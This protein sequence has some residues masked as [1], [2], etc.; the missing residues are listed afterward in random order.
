MKNIHLVLP[1]LLLCFIFTACDKKGEFSSGPRAGNY[2]LAPDFVAN[3]LIMYTSTDKNTNQQFIRNYLS[4]RIGVNPFFPEVSRDSLVSRTFP[5][6]GIYP[7]APTV[8]NI[9]ISEDGEFTFPGS[10][11][12][13]LNKRTGRISKK[14]E[15]YSIVDTDFSLITGEEYQRCPLSFAGILVSNA[16]DSSRSAYTDVVMHVTERFPIRF[17][18]GMPE[19]YLTGIF[20][21]NG[22]SWSM[23][24]D[25]NAPHPDLM[26]Q[27]K[28]GDTIVTQVSVLSFLKKN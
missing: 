28:F 12:G 26:S 9:N 2:T 21:W 11:W 14:I 17:K 5:P 13:M 15:G 6:P 27:L 25:L 20:Y 10:N 1:T 23:N 3:E 8:I 7:V 4:R 19:M 16:I 22:C 18:D 24:R